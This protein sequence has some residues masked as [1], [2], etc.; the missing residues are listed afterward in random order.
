MKKP[1]FDVTPD[2]LKAYVEMFN[3]PLPEAN[4]P[5]HVALLQGGLAGL[6]D[7]RDLDVTGVEPFVT[8][9][10]DRILGGAE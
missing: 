1:E 8:F 3:V 4:I 7:L 10:V 5:A 2:R 9:P 6:A